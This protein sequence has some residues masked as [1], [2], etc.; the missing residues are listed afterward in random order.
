[1][2]LGTNTEAVLRK[3]LLGES[4]VQENDDIELWLMSDEQAY[5]LLEAAEDDLIDDALAGRLEARDLPRFYSH[6]LAAP[7][8]QRKLRFSRSFGRVIEAAQ[9][10]AEAPASSSFKLL[11]ALRYRPAFAYAAYALVLILLAGSA[12][13]LFKVAELQRELRSATN[14]LT[15]IGRDREDLQRQLN[16]TKT[17]SRNLQE[18]VR[19]TEAAGT[20]KPPAGPLL[21]ALS[22]V[23]GITRSSGDIPKLTLAPNT[24]TVQFFLL[25]LDDNFTAYRANLKDAEDREIWSKDKIPSTAGRDGKS[26][27]LTVPA[28]LL[29]NG[30][31]SFTLLGLPS[32][33]TPESVGR[34]SFHA[35]R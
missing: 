3:Y 1:M 16:E 33:G 5:E 7:E 32:S 21:L 23:P 25:L 11:E 14:Q 24:S 22:L 18:Q 4:S 17:V 19:A 27:V 10:P 29:T 31:Y 34:Y 20:V 12:W 26:V 13:S 35:S 2:K 8:R 28:E 30:D 9:K 6:F 15:A